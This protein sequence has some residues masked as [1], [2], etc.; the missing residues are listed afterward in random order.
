MMSYHGDMAVGV[1]GIMVVVQAGEGN[2]VFIQANCAWQVVRALV[3]LY[4][5]PVEQERTRARRGTNLVLAT[6]N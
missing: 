3:S 4:G 6:K 2:G 5:C 1:S